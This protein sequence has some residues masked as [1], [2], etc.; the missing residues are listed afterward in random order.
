M[1]TVEESN[2][3]QVLSV[4][5]GHLHV[6]SAVLLA[7]QLVVVRDLGGTDGIQATV[8]DLVGEILEHLFECMSIFRSCTEIGSN[9]TRVGCSCFILIILNLV[10]KIS[11]WVVLEGHL[12]CFCSV[13][14]ENIVPLAKFQQAWVGSPIH[15][16]LVNIPSVEIQP[17]SNVLCASQQICEPTW[18]TCHSLILFC[19]AKMNTKGD[20]VTTTRRATDVGARSDSEYVART[21]GY[22]T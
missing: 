11:L 21:I 2:H 14:R 10:K 7:V 3:H 13:Q 18:N 6:L 15:I 17:D 1:P 19:L 9:A 8:V 12:S 4:E 22:I 16:R 5:L 20:T